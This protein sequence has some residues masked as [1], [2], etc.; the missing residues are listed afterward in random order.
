MEFLTS[1]A[2]IS[3]ENSTITATAAGNYIA[4]FGDD[5]YLIKAVKISS[6]NFTLTYHKIILNEELNQELNI[7]KNLESFVQSVL[8]ETPTF[9]NRIILSSN[10]DILEITKRK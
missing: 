8:G 9:I 4:K 7:I 3:C 10:K 2:G 6:D 5:Y 1:Y